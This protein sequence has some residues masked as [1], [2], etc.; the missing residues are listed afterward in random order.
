MTQ[1]Q[2]N[3]KTDIA[4][5]RLY[6]RIEADDL[7][8]DTKNQKVE[9]I[10]RQA[11]YKWAAAIALICISAATLIFTTKPDMADK[12]NLLTLENKKGAVTLVTTLEDGSIVYLAGDTKL[13]YPSHFEKNKREVFLSGNALFDISGN[14]DRPFLI[15]TKEIRIEVLGTS[16]Y[17]KDKID[18]TFEL[19]VQQGKVKVTHKENGAER[20][21]EAGQTICLL[22][23]KLS[24]YQTEDKN[25][26]NLYTQKIQFKDEP[27]ESILHVV[28]K[29]LNKTRLQTTP[30]LS[31]RPLTVTFSNNSPE[32]VAQ[33]ICLA[34]DL[35]Y[36]EKN[37]ILL[38]SETN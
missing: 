12:G 7:L 29:K 27:L 6:D 9:K 31:K 2:Y 25:L 1:I 36:E 35:T 21:V 16:F 14:K 24:V 22:S 28:N 26:F 10:L 37:G 19:A 33:L 34:L 20:I 13:D 38:I 5:N 8:S 4:W 18:T 32:K 3:S 23:D 17:I 11:Y 30:E 15:D